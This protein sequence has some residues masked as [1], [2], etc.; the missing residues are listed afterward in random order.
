MDTPGIRTLLLW[1]LAPATALAAPLRFEGPTRW[2]DIAV[3]LPAAN[4]ARTAFGK[5]DSNATADL[6]LYN[7]ERGEAY[8]AFSNGHGFGPPQLAARGL[9]RFQN[10]P[11]EIALADVNGD[12]LDDLVILNHGADDVP[13]AATAVVAFSTGAGFAF[14]GPPVKNDSWC[15]SYQT[16]LAGDVTGDHR[17]DLVAFTPN[18]GTVWAS[19]SQGSQIGP[20]AIWNGYFC[21]RGE[22]CA[23]G[24]VDG[25]GRADAIL[26]KPNAPDIQKG[27]VLWARSTGTA[28][29]DVKYG[30]GYFCIASERCLVGDVNGDKRADIAL[31]KGWGT[32]GQTLEVLVSLSDG[33]KFLNAS[34]FEWARP[35]F[36]DPAGR[37]FGSFALADVTGDARADLVE[38]GVVGTAGGQRASFA[39]DVFAVT[40][41]APSPQNPPSTRPPADTGFSAVKV[42]NCHPDQDRLSLW[43]LDNTAGTSAQVGPVDAMYSESG[44]CPDPNDQPETFSL[45]NGHVHT[46]IAVDPQAIGCNGQSDP[47]ILGCINNSATFRGLATG[48][49]C[50]WVLSA[51]PPSCMGSLQTRS[52]PLTPPAAPPRN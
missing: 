5:V 3:G 45:V 11:F 21:L 15:A 18:F 6:V 51:Q 33:T 29:V 48:P 35:P 22:V 50:H 27:N 30:H 40:E 24:D 41:R 23:L 10:E 16:C 8:V 34:P 17:G 42:Y 39:V 25:D 9:P 43:N 32:G 13:G 2:I 49:V 26:F 7:S 4:A 38:F 12:G 28:F 37:T 1:A 47:T 46:I 20:N 14:S 36:F 52:L 19:P 31:T 44:Y